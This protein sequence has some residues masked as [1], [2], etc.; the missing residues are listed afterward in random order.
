M[1]SSNKDDTQSEDNPKMNKTSKNEDNLK[2]EMI[3]NK[4]KLR[5]ASR[6]MIWQCGSESHNHLPSLPY[7]LVAFA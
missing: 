4:K 5:P 1:S 3:I 7:G 6:N 2:I